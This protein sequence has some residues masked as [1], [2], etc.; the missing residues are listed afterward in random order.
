[1]INM[2]CARNCVKNC[3]SLNK[4]GSSHKCNHNSVDFS[5]DGAYTVFKILQSKGMYYCL[6]IDDNG[7]VDS[8]SVFGT[9]IGCAEFCKITDEDTKKSL[10]RKYKILSNLIR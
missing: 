3:N 6:K 9:E 2:K 10:I 5:N 1:M 8:K 4:T 7:L